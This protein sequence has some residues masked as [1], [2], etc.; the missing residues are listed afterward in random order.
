MIRGVGRRLRVLALAALGLGAPAL[1]QSGGDRL[2]VPYDVGERLEYEVRF[3]RLKV[4]SGTMEVAGIQEVRGRETW[5]TVFTVRGGNFM[6]RVN[7]RYESWIDTRTG[8]SLRFRQDQHEGNRDVERTFEFFP[9]RAM[10]SE[11]EEPEEPSVHNPL[12]DGSF[13]YFVRSI[14]LNVGETYSFERYFRPDR[15][16]VTIRVLRRERI[17]VPAGEFDAIVVQPIIKSRGL[18]SEDGHAEIWLSDDENHIMLQM[19]SGLKIGSLN[20]FLKSYRPAP[21]RTSANP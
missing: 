10:F 21:A 15:N 2:P 20:L 11:N 12:D 13:I 1:A 5:H 18:F 6:Y 14:P 19:K 17:R 7:D 8:N 16:P 3:G 9:D 4:G